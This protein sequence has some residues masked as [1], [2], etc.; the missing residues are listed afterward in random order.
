MELPAARA[1]NH[2]EHGWLDMCLTDRGVGKMG[3]RYKSIE[4]HIAVAKRLADSV[5]R[6]D[7]LLEDTGARCVDVL[8]RRALKA[9]LLMAI[10]GLPESALF[11]ELRH[12]LM[13]RWFLDL[14]IDEALSPPR[15]CVAW[16]HLQARGHARNFFERFTRRAVELALITSS[17]DIRS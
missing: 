11:Q 10:F 1:R 6:N 9:A 4:Q 12:N 2:D 3:K 7:V 14:G 17:G 8:H 5:I 16:R 13:F 15:L